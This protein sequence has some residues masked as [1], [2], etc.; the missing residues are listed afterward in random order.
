MLLP[1]QMLVVDG[2]DVADDDS[3]GASVL[4]L[5]ILVTMRDFGVWCIR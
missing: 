1:M 3:D 5:L 4:I 2:D